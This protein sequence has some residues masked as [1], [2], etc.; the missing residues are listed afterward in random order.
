[1]DLFSLNVG[2]TDPLG[3]IRQG[4]KH[5]CPLGIQA[6]SVT[7]WRVGQVLRLLIMV[8]VAVLRAAIE[9]IR[10]VIALWKR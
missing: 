2:N 3:L 6:G 5:G 8:I 10:L 9:W 1:M 4:A 7:G